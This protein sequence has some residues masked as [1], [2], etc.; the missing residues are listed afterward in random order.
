MS[1][2]F[3]IKESKMETMFMKNWFQEGRD[4]VGISDLAE[5]LASRK[6][7]QTICKIFNSLGKTEKPTAVRPQLKPAELSHEPSKVSEK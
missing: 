7:V 3:D 1:C 6:E 5:G 4:C 2:N